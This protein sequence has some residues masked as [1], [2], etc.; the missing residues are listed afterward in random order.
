MPFGRT[1]AWRTVK[2]VVC[3]K[4]IYSLGGQGCLSSDCGEEKHFC[5]I[6]CGNAYQY[7][8]SKMVTL[9]RGDQIKEVKAQNAPAYKKIGWYTRQDSNLHRSTYGTTA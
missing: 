1:T 4:M 9:Y 7:K 6:K 2:D 3:V 8:H 5:S